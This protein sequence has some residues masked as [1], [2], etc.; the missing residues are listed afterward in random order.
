MAQTLVEK[1]SPF[2]RQRSAF[3]HGRAANFPG[4]GHN[5]R[6]RA[7]GGGVGDLSK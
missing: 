2:S 5:T 7:D 4:A 3:S 1:L 6:G